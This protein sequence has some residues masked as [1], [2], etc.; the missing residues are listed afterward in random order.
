MEALGSAVSL[1]RPKV[2]GRTA[3]ANGARSADI[4]TISYAIADALAL[5]EP[6]LQMD[7]QSARATLHGKT[8]VITGGGG[9][10]GSAMRRAGGGAPPFLASAETRTVTGALVP[11][12]G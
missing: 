11:V 6:L 5:A 12:A 10:L 7:A 4:P 9:V 1:T 2:A 8:V 3:P